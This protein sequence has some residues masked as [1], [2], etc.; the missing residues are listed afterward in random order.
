M[1]TALTANGADT[2]TSTFSTAGLS[3][4]NHTIQAFYVPSGDFLASNGSVGQAVDAA[5]STGVTSN[6]N[7]ATVG[8]TVTFTATVTNTSGSGGPP[9]GSVMFTSQGSA[10]GNTTVVPL[11]T[12]LLSASNATQATAS[13]T[14]TYTIADDYT[15]VAHYIPTGDFL[16]NPDVSL[17]ETVNP[18]VVILH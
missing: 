3:V 18:E 12:V 8:D 6:D 7:P 16:T 15:I 5:T 17:M 14:F 10:P 11:G 2:A 4:G 1:G 9:T 13:V